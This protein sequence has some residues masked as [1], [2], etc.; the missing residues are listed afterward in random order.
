MKV[1]QAGGTLDKIL[2]KNWVGQNVCKNLNQHFDQPNTRCFFH[3][4]CRQENEIKAED[5]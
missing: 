5:V 4:Y 2:R 1:S 3:S